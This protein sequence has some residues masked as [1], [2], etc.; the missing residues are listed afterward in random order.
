M[1]QCCL[2]VDTDSPPHS[3][4]G[5][6]SAGFDSL[7]LGLLKQALRQLFCKICLPRAGRREREGEKEV[8]KERQRERDERER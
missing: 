5:V 7:T 8:E 1:P 2:R 6:T 4:A 3:Q